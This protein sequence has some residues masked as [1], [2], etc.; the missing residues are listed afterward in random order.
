MEIMI[1][2]MILKALLFIA[3]L[4]L[5]SVYYSP[6]PGHFRTLRTEYLICPSRI[7]VY[8][9]CFLPIHV[10]IYMCRK[11]II[12][13]ILLI[14]YYIFFTNLLISWWCLKG[15]LWSFWLWVVLWSSSFYECFCLP[16]THSWGC[17][18]MQMTRYT[19]LPMVHTIPLIYR[20]Q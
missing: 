18:C 9:F 13:W 8:A 7:H 10:C 11:L 19:F 12:L 5:F 20:W 3:L 16:P 1:S 17:I 6:G 2:K 4:F 15:S 14:M